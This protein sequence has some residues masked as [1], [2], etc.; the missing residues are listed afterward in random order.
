MVDIL[1][2]R[3]RSYVITGTLIAA[4][5]FLVFSIAVTEGDTYSAQEENF[6]NISNQTEL[7]IV[8]VDSEENLGTLKIK[9]MSGNSSEIV[10]ETDDKIL[11]VKFIDK[12]L[13]IS[14]FKPSKGEF[15]FQADFTPAKGDLIEVRTAEEISISAIL[16]D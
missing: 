4:F 11:S 6:S 9:P 8:K 15:R 10:L 13:P 5:S 7:I 14:E 3:Y 12:D 16:T 2:P 1:K